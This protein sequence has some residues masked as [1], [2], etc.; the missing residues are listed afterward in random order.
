MAM[1][2]DNRYLEALK[3]Y[4]SVNN[5][6]VIAGHKGSAASRGRIKRRNSGSPDLEAQVGFSFEFDVDWVLSGGPGLHL[7]FG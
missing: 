4:K 5:T 7:G 2:M 1:I 6:I 3:N